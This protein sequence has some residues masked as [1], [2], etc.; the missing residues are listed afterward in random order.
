MT[1]IPKQ[2]SKKVR[3]KIAALNR[4]WTI[5]KRRDHYFLH[6]EDEPMICVA[7]NSSKHNDYQTMKSIQHIKKVTQ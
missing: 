4:P 3:Q 1:E 7:G 6:V 2:V 5:V